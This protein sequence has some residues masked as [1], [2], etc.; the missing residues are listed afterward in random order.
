MLVCVQDV[1][2]QVFSV[3]ER[4]FYFLFYFILLLFFKN[5]LYLVMLTCEG[6]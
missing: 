6:C 2:F 3:E 5:V 4:G 1:N